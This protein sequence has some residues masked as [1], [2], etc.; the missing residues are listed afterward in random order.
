[1]RSVAMNI[2]HI[3]ASKDPVTP[4]ILRAVLAKIATIPCQKQIYLAVLLM[5]IEFLRQSNIAPATVATFD[6]TRHLTPMD[7]TVNSKGLQVNIKWSKT[8]QKSSDA[9]SILLPRTQDPKLC[10][11]RA[12]QAYITAS[13]PLVNGPLL[14]HPDGKPLTIRYISA[15]W[16]TLLRAAQLSTT[17]YS[18]H[19]L[20]R[21]AAGFA[22]NQ[23]K[24]NLN[25]VMNQGTW[26]SM[27][28]RAYI[29][30]REVDTNTVHAALERV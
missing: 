28:V 26:K 22:Y 30:P 3:P 13:R 10:P 23:Q 25:D 20:R 17:A 1:M 18:L 21:G 16:A 7:L 27:A 5:Y 15:Q 11:V 4:E 8:L 14:I 12:Y 24:A 29:K 6:A 2:R 9:K 19:S